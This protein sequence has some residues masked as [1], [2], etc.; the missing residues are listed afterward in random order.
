MLKL[1]PNPTFR[2]KVGIPIPGEEKR[3][4]V[5][6]IFN[7]MTREEFEA[8]DFKTGE[9]DGLMKICAGWEGVDG[10]FSRER[11]Q[12]LINVYPGA[13][14]AIGNAFGRELYGNRLGN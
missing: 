10:E 13:G 12:T 6:F 9:L 11:M 5:W 7:H 8:F 14:F 3:A 4:E 2:A 1:Q